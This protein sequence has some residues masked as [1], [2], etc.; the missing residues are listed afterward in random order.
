[1]PYHRQQRFEWCRV[2]GNWD[3]EWQSVVFSDETRIYLWQSDRHQRVRRRPGERSQEAAIIEVHTYPTPG[4]MV[5]EDIGYDKRTD[6]V[7]AEGTLTAH[8]LW[9]EWS[10]YQMTH[11]SRIMQDHT[12]QLT[13]RNVLEKVRNL[14]WPVRSLDLSP[15][16]I[17]HVSDEMGRH[18]RSYQP[19]A[20]NLHELTQHMF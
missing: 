5:W 12:L 16:L 14:D 4:I 17:G 9:Q 7:L 2:R 6:L 18:K 1:M 11:Y 15:A 20:S 8:Q 10:G 3:I 13:K 19:Q